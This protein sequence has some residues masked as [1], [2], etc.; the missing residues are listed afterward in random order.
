M[1][2]NDK[3]STFYVGKIV[4]FLVIGNLAWIQKAP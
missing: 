2:F 4:K 1:N 3:F